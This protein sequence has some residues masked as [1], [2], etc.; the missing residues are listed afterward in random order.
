MHKRELL[1]LGLPPGRVIEAAKVACETSREE[2]AP[3]AVASCT[4]ARRSSRSPTIA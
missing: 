3:R 2:P 4:S 1:K